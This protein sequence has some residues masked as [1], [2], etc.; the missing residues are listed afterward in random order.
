[1]RVKLGQEVDAYVAVRSAPLVSVVARIEEP[2]TGKVIGSDTPA[3][4]EVVKGK[5]EMPT[6][7]RAV[8]TLPCPEQAGD[9]LIVWENDSPPAWAVRVPLMVATADEAHALSLPG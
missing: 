3:P 7:V 8:V 6:V 9:Y 2:V 4:V 1:M 5:D